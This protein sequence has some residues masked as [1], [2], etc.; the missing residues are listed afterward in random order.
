MCTEDPWA[1]T[2]GGTVRT[3]ALL[4]AIGAAGAEVTLVHPPV[5]TRAERTPGFPT[6]VATTGLAALGR[7]KR[8][9]LP[10]PTLVGARDRTVSSRIE[11]LCCSTDLMIATTLSTAPYWRGLSKAGLWMDYSDL[12]SEF[13]ARESQHRRGAV[14]WSAALQSQHFHRLESEYNS[15]ASIVT[16]AGFSDCNVLLGQGTTATWL[17]T[18]IMTAPDE[19]I[20]ARAP[21]IRT[22]GFIGNFD[23]HPN[24]DALD[25]LVTTWGPEL[26]RRGWRVAVAGKA[27]EALSLPDWIICLG[28]PDSVSDFY[29]QI[30]LALAPIR[31]GGGMKV[32]VVEALLHGRPV[33]ASEFAMAGFPR[34]LRELVTVV[35]IAAP[36]FPSPDSAP[37]TGSRAHPALAPF[38]G[39]AFRRSVADRLRTALAL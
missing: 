18:P 5:R 32:K 1:S 37:R 35:D 25:A 15:A 19:E 39:A 33:V 30:D 28:S 29:E 2:T 24:R 26:V 27:S 3:R 23:F 22:A 21:G 36:T 13:A 14:R 11:Q 6:R 16:A 4:D 17:P 38:T 20:R 10:L 31:L 7:V 34:D 12:W 9:I 8:E